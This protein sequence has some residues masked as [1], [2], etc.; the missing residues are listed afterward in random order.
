MLA[1]EEIPAYPLSLEARR[2][3]KSNLIRS[4]LALADATKPGSSRQAFSDTTKSKSLCGDIW[5]FDPPPALIHGF[6]LMIC[7]RAVVARPTEER[8]IPGL[9]HGV[10]FPELG[11]ACRRTTAKKECTQHQ[12]Y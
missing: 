2:V 3:L 1:S 11:L 6:L 9:I 7:R 10:M 8:M 12:Q 4:K 5:Y